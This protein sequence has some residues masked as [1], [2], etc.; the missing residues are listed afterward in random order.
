[1][2]LLIGTTNE[3]KFKQFKKIF[4]SVENDFELFSLNDLNIVDDIEEDQDTLLKNAKKKAKYFAE[5]SGLIALSDDFG[6]FVDFLNG[7]PGIHAKRW[8]SGT[9]RDRCKEIL[10]KLKEVK[11]RERKAFYLGTLAIY[12]PKT[13]KFWEYEL[14][15]EGRVIEDFQGDEAFGY[16]QIFSPD[17]FSDK[18]YAE[19]TDEELKIVGHRSRGIR[20]FIKDYNLK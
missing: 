20:E 10:K 5:K 7:A 18:T 19:L 2:K 8:C 16:N 12:N 17:E 11:S 6:F 1:M 13:K 15:T 9:D 4:D 3:D 14:K